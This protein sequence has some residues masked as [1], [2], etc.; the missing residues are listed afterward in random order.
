ML[1]VD[2]FMDSNWTETFYSDKIVKVSYK[3]KKNSSLEIRRFSRGLVSDWFSE[4][5]GD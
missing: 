2:K 4:M 3:K 5:L 1:P